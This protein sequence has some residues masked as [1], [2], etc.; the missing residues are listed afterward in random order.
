MRTSLIL[1]AYLMHTSNG[2]ICCAEFTLVARH[3]CLVILVAFVL[4][5]FFLNFAE[6]FYLL[7]F[8]LTAYCCLSSY[9]FS[10]PLSCCFCRPSSRF[11]AV[12][13]VVFSLLSWA[14]FSLFLPAVILFLSAILPL[15]CTL[16]FPF[17]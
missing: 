14:V 17:F 11:L 5:P 6:L 13:L 16:F 2:I 9:C 7:L 12:L 10:R 15:F 1:F 4:Q 3:G 8:I